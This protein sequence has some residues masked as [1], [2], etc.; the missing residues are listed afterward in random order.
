[1]EKSPRGP[2]SIAQEAWALYQKQ[3]KSLLPTAF[4]FTMITLV[5]F[6]LGIFWPETLYLTVPFLLIPF[7][8]AYQMA[9]SSLRRGKNV[10]G[11]EFLRFYAAYYQTPFLGCYRVIWHAVLSFFWGLAAMFAVGLLTYYT[12]YAVNPDFQSAVMDLANYVQSHTMDEVVTYMAASQPIALFQNAMTLVDE[13]VFFYFFLHY[14]ASYGLAPYLRSA[15][16]GANS[17]VANEIYVGGLRSIHPSFWK[18]YYRALWPAIP[19]IVIGYGAGMGIAF[20]TPA[21]A[22][23]ISAAGAAGA[24]LFLLPFLPYYFNVVGLLIEKYHGNFV[25]YSLKMAQNTLAELEEAKKLSE[26][27]AASLRKSIEAAKKQEEKGPENPED[28]SGDD[29]EE[30]DDDKPDDPIDKN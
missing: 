10:G 2:N 1:M 8:F 17:R 11:N 16:A 30:N 27:E 6:A 28:K 22:I 3:A 23:Q 18:D 21:E 24:I 25:S 5:V 7:F 12:A 15:I 20:L 19:L 14:I 29:S 26:E 13:G 9:S 4:N